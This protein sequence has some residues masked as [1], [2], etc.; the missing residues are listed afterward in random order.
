MTHEQRRQYES[1]LE[2]SRLL[3]EPPHFKKDIDDFQKKADI[4]AEMG[5]RQLETR[6]QFWRLFEDKF[7]CAYHVFLTNKDTREAVLR[8]CPEAFG[9]RCNGSPHDK[10]GKNFSLEFKESG[11]EFGEFF[12]NYSFY[13]TVDTHLDKVMAMLGKTDFPSSGPGPLSGPQAIYDLME[14][15]LTEASMKFNELHDEDGAKESSTDESDEDDM[16][17]MNAMD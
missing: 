8:L 12:K 15:Y 3:Q 6:K 10:E 1:D 14:W 17:D 7:G 5:E 16:D 11:K 9:P 4:L 2:K 13:T